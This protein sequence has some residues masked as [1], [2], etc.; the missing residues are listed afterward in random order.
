MAATTNKSS[1]GLS[2]SSGIMGARHFF[3][4]FRLSRICR[5]VPRSGYEGQGPLGLRST[6]GPA[7]QGP[8]LVAGRQASE[9]ST[10]SGEAAKLCCTPLNHRYFAVKESVKDPLRVDQ[11]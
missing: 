3:A 8:T 11:A 10:A 5:S 6:D 7:P 2:V 1:K 9:G 4:E